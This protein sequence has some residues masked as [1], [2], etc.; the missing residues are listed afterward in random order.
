MGPTYQ[1]PHTSV[2]E[3][4]YRGTSGTTRNASTGQLAI[5]AQPPKQNPAYA[6]HTNH[7][8]SQTLSHKPQSVTSYTQSQ[9]ILILN[10]SNPNITT[11]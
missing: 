3:T 9:P 8:W 2:N 11:P 6:Q 5:E 7:T 4:W 10:H 1:R